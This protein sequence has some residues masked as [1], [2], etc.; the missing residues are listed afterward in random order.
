MQ[1][2]ERPVGDFKLSQRSLGMAI[3]SSGFLAGVAV[4]DVISN[5]VG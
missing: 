4:L 2:V 3:G 5:I 1:M